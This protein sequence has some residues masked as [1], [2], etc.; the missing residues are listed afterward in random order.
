MWL[1]GVSLALCASD[2]F[3]AGEREEIARLGGVE[4]EVARDGEIFLVTDPAKDNRS[5]PVLTDEVHAGRR[6]VH[7]DD[8]SSRCEPRRQHALEHERADARLVAQRADAARAGVE[9][10]KSARLGT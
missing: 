5:Y 2:V 8:E 1:A 10:L 4:D 7:S 9:R 6:D 3:D